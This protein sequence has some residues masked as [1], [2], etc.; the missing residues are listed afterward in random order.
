MLAGMSHHFHDPAGT[1]KAW[2]TLWLFL[3]WIL[4]TT[5]V[6]GMV[7]PTSRSSL[8]RSSPL[9]SGDLL[10]MIFAAVLRFARFPEVRSGGHLDVSERP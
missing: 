7:R 5:V 8:G 10:L 6:L 4:A 1:T 2:H 3:G 9:G